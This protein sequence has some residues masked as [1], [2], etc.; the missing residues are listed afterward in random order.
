MARRKHDEGSV[1]QR[2]DGRYVAQV[3]LENGKMKQRYFKTEKEANTALLKMLHKKEQ[4]TLPTGPSQ[5]LKAHLGTVAKKVSLGFSGG[6]TRQKNH[7]CM[8]EVRVK[9]LV[10]PSDKSTTIRI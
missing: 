6:V 5:T 2:K 9:S 4:G 3:R 10:E 7:R 1:F 8:V